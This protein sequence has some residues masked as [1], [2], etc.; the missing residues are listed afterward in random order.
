MTAVVEQ[1]HSHLRPDSTPSVAAVLVLDLAGLFLGGNIEHMVDPAARLDRFAGS[2][3]AAAAVVPVLS[4]APEARS[5]RVAGRL[6][7]AVPEPAP[8]LATQGHS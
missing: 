2:I 8:E 1:R 7:A 3:A 5:D 4:L 6:A